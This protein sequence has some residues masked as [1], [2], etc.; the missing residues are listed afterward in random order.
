MTK[1]SELD[2]ISEKIKNT[3]EVIRKYKKDNGIEDTDYSHI[4]KTKL[5]DINVQIQKVEGYSNFKD[6]VKSIVSR[7]Y[8]AKL[9]LTKGSNDYSKILAN[10]MIQILTKGDI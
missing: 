9:N 8:E 6:G 4:L 2:L 1:S 7:E 5:S 3:I 10:K